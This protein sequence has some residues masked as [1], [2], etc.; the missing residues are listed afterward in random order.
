MTDRFWRRKFVNSLLMMSTATSCF[1]ILVNIR[2]D[3]PVSVS[4]TRTCLWSIHSSCIFSFSYE[5]RFLTFSWRGIPNHDVLGFVL[6][7]R[8]YYSALS[9]VSSH[10]FRTLM[11]YVAI[12]T[13][14]T[15]DD[16]VSIR[17]TWYF[18]VPRIKSPLER[19]VVNIA[20]FLRNPQCV[21]KYNNYIFFQV[22]YF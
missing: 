15:R 13:T 21:K 6:E 20:C 8:S 2:L 3:T 16:Y 12:S 14:V 10:V 11:T 18:F 22:P 4:D 19:S 7:E 5:L 17:F 1:F 9:F